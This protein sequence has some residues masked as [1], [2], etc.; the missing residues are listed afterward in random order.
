M[1]YDIA[2]AKPVS[3]SGPPESPRYFVYCRTQVHHRG[4]AGIVCKLC[5]GKELIELVP[6]KRRV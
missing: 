6:R 2:P 4:I 1:K 3:I 5:G